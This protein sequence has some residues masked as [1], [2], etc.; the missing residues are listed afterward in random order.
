MDGFFRS[1]D[2]ARKRRIHFHAS[3][4]QLHDGMFRRQG[5]ADALGGA[6]DELLGDCRLLCFDEFHVHDIGDAMLITRLFR[7]LF[8]RGITLGLH[9]QLRARELLPTRCT[10]SGSC[11]LSA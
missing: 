5:Q 1:A 9:V 7:E 4:R 10:T 8:R 2:L 6:L 11:R 3:S